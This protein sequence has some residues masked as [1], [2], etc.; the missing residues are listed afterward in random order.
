MTGTLGGLFA[1]LGS[2]LKGNLSLVRLIRFNTHVD[3]RGALTAIE[4]ETDVPFAIRRLFYVHRV[5]AGGDRAGH[6]HPDTDQVLIAISGAL[7]VEVKDPDNSGS[8]RLDDPGVG[9]YVPPMV[10]VRLY[11]FTTGAVCLAAASTHYVPE[12]VLR[13]WEV[14]RRR[15]AEAGMARA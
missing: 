11:N 2:L 15:A 4:G 14:Y 7:D 10:W 12:A 3:P 6:A 1:S 9:L 8:F 13:D 5:A